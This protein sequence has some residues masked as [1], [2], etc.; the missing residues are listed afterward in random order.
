MVL[1]AAQ[2]A[3]HPGIEQ[4]EHQ[5]CMHRDSGLQAIGRLPGA[6]TYPGDKLADP[7]GGMQGQRHAI[8]GQHVALGYQAADLD[9]QALQGRV[10]I[11]HRATRRALLPQHM[12]GSRA[13][14]SSSSMP[15]TA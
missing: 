11:T 12:P 3:L 13:W 10:D 5:R 9:L 6:V 4:V 1:A 14:R 2:G 8:A 15:L 7:P